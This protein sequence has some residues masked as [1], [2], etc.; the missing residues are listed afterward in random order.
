MLLVD[1]HHDVLMSFLSFTFSR[2]IV[3]RQWLLQSCNKR[4]S[5][6]PSRCFRSVN[7]C[8]QV[9]LTPNCDV[10]V[11]SLFKLFIT[12]T[13]SRWSEE[14]RSQAGRD[15]WHMHR[16]TVQVGLPVNKREWSVGEQ[17]GGKR[18]SDSR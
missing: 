9:T 14:R 7:H 3:A 8:H 11:F 5:S 2:T 10:F 4:E 1:F 12:R 16:D 6:F 17:K 15:Y 13:P 18:S